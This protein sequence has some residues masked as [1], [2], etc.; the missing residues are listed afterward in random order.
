MSTLR[1]RWGALPPAQRRVLLLSALAFVMLGSVSVWWS[2][3][4]DW[5]VLF[6]D[7]DGRDAAQ[8]QQELAAAG[9]PFQSTPDGVAIEVAA[10]NL[11]KARVAIA[12]KG[13][14]Q[15][16]RLGFELFD[17]PNWAGSEF[18]EKVNY[19]RAL[20][21]EL[22]HTIAT[23]DAVRSARVHLVLPVR[24]A[25]SSEDQA[26]K[27]SVVLTLR[28]TVDPRT[29]GAAMR[30]L[31]AGAVEGLSPGAVVL[32]DA[33]GRLDFSGNS[34]QGLSH[35]EE[36]ALQQKV[37]ALLEPLA[38]VGNV[39]ATVNISYVTGSEERSDEVYDP[40]S[41]VPVSTQKTE[42]MSQTARAG[43]IAGT[44]S[45]TPALVPAAAAPASGSNAGQA[46]TPATTTTTAGS[47]PVQSTREETSSYAVTRHTVHTE[48][49][50]GRVR[51]IAAAVVI[52]DRAVPGGEGK[53]SRTVWKPR[54]ADEMKRLQQIAQ[55]A[56][57]FDAARGD[58]VVVQNLAFSGNADQVAPSGFA[59]VMSQGKDLLRSQP[60]LLRSLT[61][62]ASLLAFGLLVLRPLGRQTVAA[63]ALPE[64]GA[65]IQDAQ[66]LLDADRPRTEGG[67]PAP[68]EVATHDSQRLLQHVAARIHA[69]PQ[70][71][72]R[73]VESWITAGTEAEV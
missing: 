50:P 47:G 57:G 14:P 67:M 27:A 62:G 6:R 4:T 23:M 13:M 68:H 10:E 43:G 48:E 8:V 73:L 45:N 19:Q 69:E 2:T 61:I 56:V 58:E 60:S 30:S 34:G 53:N 46:A 32:I 66:L 25:F 52:N 44:A 64:P 71:S 21:G 65:R 70:G 41:A 33:D 49:G 24:G 11:D 29:E 31:V 5:R 26:A 16:G 22:E 1:A 51:R 55:A 3:R 15:S 28:H 54:S 72:A 35:E 36:A 39:R 12:A 37:I 40:N 18:D 38:G 7:L 42:Q 20:E 59:A 17:K 9:I 63:L